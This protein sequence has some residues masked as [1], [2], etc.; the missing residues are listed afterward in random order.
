MKRNAWFFLVTLFLALFAGTQNAAAQT[1]RSRL[2]QGLG[3]Y[4]AG[5]WADAALEL[6]RSR[7]EAANAGQA[8]ESLYWLSLAEFFLGDYAASL[9]DMDELQRIAPAGL[10]IDNII[11]YRGRCLYYLNRPE[12]AL[13]VFRLYESLLNRSRA[14]TP[15]T[16]A[17]KTTLS[18]WIG[19][20]LYSLGRFDQA[21]ELF[22]EV[23]A[24]KPRIEQHEAASYRL[25]M[26]RQ[27][28]LQGEILGMLDWSYSEYLRLAGEYRER[29]AGFN[30]TIAA[31]QNQIGAGTGTAGAVTADPAPLL[32]LD[33]RVTEYQRLLDNTAERIRLLEAGLS[34]TERAAAP[35]VPGQ[36]DAIRRIRALM[37][38]ADQL[39]SSLLP[40][41]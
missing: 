12:E 18:Y 5:Y 20:C 4:R 39:R 25:A 31:L 14:D 13:T 37:A 29:E 6:R 15:R 30:A 27:N 10:R 38:E 23:V 11:Y 7:M 2:E 41:T 34:E 32:Q 28:R 21:A 33:A 24:T 8:A 9:R 1:H 35:L 3:L 36:E 22:A 19:E 40:Q 17:Q 16:A 26:L